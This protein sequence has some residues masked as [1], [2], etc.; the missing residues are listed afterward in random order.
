MTGSHL[1]RREFGR[2]LAASGAALGWSHGSGAALE[3]DAFAGVTSAPLVP[4]PQVPDE[5][6]WGTVR[7]RFLIPRDVAFLK[8]AN[9]CP[10]SL[11]AIEAH[12]RH[13]RQYE[14]DPSPAFR[15]GLFRLREEARTLLA[16]ALRATPEEIVFTRESG[17]D[18][19]GGQ[20]PERL[21]SPCS[22]LGET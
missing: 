11:A 10:A 20:R 6:F 1:S 19:S 8:A 5:A 9:L 13:L 7:A 2:L 22:A 12:E 21:A 4:T 17:P 16:A 15:D 3:D 18:F 14:A